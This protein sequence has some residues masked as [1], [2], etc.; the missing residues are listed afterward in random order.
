M[1]SGA[2]TRSEVSPIMSNHPLHDTPLRRLGEHA[3][4][5]AL[6]RRPIEALG[7]WSAI[8]LPFLYVPLVVSGLQTSGTRYA[9]AL[10]IA[11]HVVSLVVGRE[12]HAD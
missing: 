6:L 2:Q 11:L 1:Q 3:E 8:A 10:L 9:F 7:F 12:Y 4:G 5:V